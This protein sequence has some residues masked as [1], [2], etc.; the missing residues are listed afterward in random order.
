[1]GARIGVKTA[2][3]LIGIALAGV[4]SAQAADWKAHPGANFPLVGGNWWNQRYSTLTKINKSTISQLGGAWMVH[5]EPGKSGIWMQATPV[6]VDGVMYITT[7]HISARDARTG[8]LKWQFPK[9][10]LGPGGGW[11]GGKDNHFNRGVVVA[12]GKVFSAASGT[13]LVALDQKTGELIWRTEL[14]T[15]PQPSFASAPAVYYDGLVYMGVAGGE[16][17]VRGQFGAYDAKTGKEVWKFWTVPGPG[18]FGNETWEGDSWKHGGAPVWTHPAIDPELGLLYLPTGN[19]SPDTDGSKRGGDNLFSASIVALDLKTGKRKWHF[20]EV[21]HDL[22]DYDGPSSPVLADITYQGRPRKI[23][24]HGSKTGMIYILDRTN[25]TPLIGIEERPVPQ[26]PEQKT[27]K[28]QPFPIGDAFVPTCPEGVPQGQLSGCVFTPYFKDRVAVSPGTNGGLAWAPMSYS[29]QTKLLYVCGTVGTA[30]FTMQGFGGLGY[31]APRGGTVTAMDPTT[32][33]IVWQKKL[34]FPCGGGSGLLSTAAGLLFQG[35]GDGLLVARD[36]TTGEVV[37]QFQTGAGADAPVSTYEVDGEQYV[38]ILAGGNQFL[39]TQFGDN[40]WAF[41]IGGKVP[42]ATAPRPPGPPPLPTAVAVDPA[43]LP[44]YVG[45]YEVQPGVELL[46]TIENGTLRLQMPGQPDKRALS[47]SSETTFFMA[48]PNVRIAFVKD[49]TG[50]VTHMMFKQG[51]NAEITATGPHPL[52]PERKEIT[53]S[54]AILAAYVGSYELQPG[55]TLD[56]TVD[57]GQL[58]VAPNGNPQ[59]LPLSAESETVFFSK[60]MTNVQFTFEKDDKGVVTTLVFRQGARE[61][62]APRK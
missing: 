33:K 42:P 46:I 39:N 44:P 10:E 29:P 7:G 17:G 3:G 51:N 24:M 18:E 20:Q 41:K 9:G 4:L 6:V 37:W 19:A 56:V 57:N 16:F 13:T 61:I 52:P 11:T 45:A 12:E 58:F 23:L 54:P 59:K 35:Q 25:G 28:T 14:Q 50:A 21:H 40:L 62:R 2:T 32:N 53:V 5:V 31:Q 27:A 48:Q 38:A 36:A 30:G 22:W 60:A 34:T 55:Q 47:A 43:V 49:A 1:M 8:E 26:Q 15:E